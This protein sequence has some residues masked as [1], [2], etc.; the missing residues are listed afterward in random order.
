MTENA[1]GLLSGASGKV[2]EA[3]QD[4]LTDTMKSA[5]SQIP[6]MDEVMKYGKLA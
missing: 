2:I 4:E 1:K 3:A 5:L 6:F